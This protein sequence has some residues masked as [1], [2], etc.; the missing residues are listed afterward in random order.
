MRVNA[1]AYLSLAAIAHFTALPADRLFI[2]PALGHYTHGKQDSP[3]DLSPLDLAACAVLRHSDRST[4]G[5]RR[6]CALATTTLGVTAFAWPFYACDDDDAGHD[7]TTRGR[8]NAPYR[9]SWRMVCLCAYLAYHA[10]PAI[11]CTRGAI[12]PSAVR[13]ACRLRSAYQ[14]CTTCYSRFFLPSGLVPSTLYAPA[15]QRIRL[16]A[17]LPSLPPVPLCSKP[18]Y[19]AL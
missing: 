18:H 14:L 3:R 9:W 17:I 7:V 15:I 1:Q 6:A 5:K 16:P 13:L 12:F 8:A 2:S 11:P 4:R 19:L 10:A